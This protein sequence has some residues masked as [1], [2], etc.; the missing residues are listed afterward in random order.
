MNNGTRNTRRLVSPNSAS[1]IEGSCFQKPSITSLNSLLF[2]N[3]AACWKTGAAEL[4]FTVEPCPN[5]TRAESRKS[6]VSTSGLRFPS[7]PL[8]ERDQG[9]GGHSFVC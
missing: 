1:S 9:R 3:V 4:A 6:L 8:E 2:R 5:R 7:P